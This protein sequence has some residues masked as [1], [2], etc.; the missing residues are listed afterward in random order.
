VVEATVRSRVACLAVDDVAGPPA[1]DRVDAVEKGLQRAR[2]GIRRAPSAVA[3]VAACQ[4][5]VSGGDEVL[6]PLREQV[7]PTR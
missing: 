3:Q 4:D 2:C 1:F 5:P 7:E 6:H